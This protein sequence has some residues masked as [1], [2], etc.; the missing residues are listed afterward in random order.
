MRYQKLFALAAAAS[1]ATVIACSQGSTPPT[2]PNGTSPG[3]IAAGPDGATL[4]ATA[5]VAVSPVGGI[6]STDLSPELVIDNASSIY[7]SNLPLSY[8]F[9]VMNQAGT[10][11]YRSNPIPAGNG[12]T[13]HEVVGDLN[14]EE[15]HTWRAYAVYQGHRGPMSTAASFKTLSRFGV[16][17]AFHRDPLAIVACRF[18]QHGGMD[19]EEV[20]D[21]LREV[22]YDLNQAGIS[23]HGG[24]GLLVKTSG[25]NCLGY[26]CDIICEGN[27]GGQNQYDILID[28]S[29]PN[30]AE[31]DN[32]TVR[33]CEIIN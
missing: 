25:N 12:R 23:D 32:P 21:F 9:E 18:D 1:T 7:V 13:A 10:L 27:G 15:T 14:N 31:V 24:F 2:A 17:C 26:S 16:S 6:E 3:L 4:K 19:E 29:V 20:V 8:V 30:W 5:P 22:A 28:D 11:V 33:P